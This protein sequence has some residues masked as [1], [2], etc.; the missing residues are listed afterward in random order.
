[1]DEI[2]FAPP[3]K[4]AHRQLRW[5]GG[6]KTKNRAVGGE[7]DGNTAPRLSE[8]DPEKMVGQTAQKKDSGQMGN[9]FS[10]VRRRV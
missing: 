10:R 8:S 9:H 1:M 7:A 3:K 2:H 5:P 6:S 4:P